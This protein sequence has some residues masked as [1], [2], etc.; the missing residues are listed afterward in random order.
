MVEDSDIP[1]LTPSVSRAKDEDDR[2][3]P[4]QRQ[5]IIAQQRREKTIKGGLLAIGFVPRDQ[6]RIALAT[7]TWFETAA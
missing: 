2:L 6:G 7:R 5:A 3:N 4:R 1:E